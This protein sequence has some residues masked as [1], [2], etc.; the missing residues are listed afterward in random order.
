MKT[1][2]QLFGIIG[3]LSVAAA[4]QGCGYHVGGRGS[5]LPATWHTIAV[6]AFANKTHSYKLE[7]RLTGAV[8]HEILA[9]TAY[10]V[11]SEPAG[12]DAVLHGEVTSIE[13]VVATFDPTSQRATSMLVTVK[14]RVWLVDSDQKEVYRNDDF[15]FRQLYEISTDVASFFDEQSPALQRLSGDFA[16]SLVSAILEKF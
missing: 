16:R 14:I 1:P 3:V 8:I 13:S 7:Q 12:A 6:P 5:S 2:N 4:L 11:V 10:H 15:V 9:R